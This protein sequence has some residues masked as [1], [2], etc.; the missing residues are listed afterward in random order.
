M[1]LKHEAL[2]EQP[3]NI[4]NQLCT[5]LSVEAPQDYLDDCASIILK[6]PN[7]TRF[8]FKWTKEYIDLVQSKIEQFDFLQ[9]YSYES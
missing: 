9:G 3:K 6:S 2:I 8:T 5:F 4:L 7:Q 1:S